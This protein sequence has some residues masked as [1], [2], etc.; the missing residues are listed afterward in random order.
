MVARPPS[1]ESWLCPTDADLHRALDVSARVRRARELGSAAIGVTMIASAPFLG[2]Y[3]LVFFALSV[4]NLQTLDWRLSRARHPARVIARS[5]LWTAAVIGGAAAATGGPVSPML[6]W[7]VIPC[8][9]AAARFR[10]EVVFVGTGITA[11]L[12]AAITF[13]VDPQGTIDHPVLLFVSI[14]LLVNL[15][16]IVSAVTSAEIEHRAEAILDPLT[17]LLNRNALGPR[18]VELETQAARSGESVALVLCDLDHFKAVNDTYGHE[19]GDRALCETAD[20]MRSVLRTFELIYRYGGEEFLI[21]LPGAT[22][23]HGAEVAERV[24]VAVVSARPGALDLT[25]SA[26][27]AAA[28]GHRV[29]L[30]SLFRAADAALYEA[31][32]A[33]R[34]RVVS[35]AA[36]P[37]LSPRATAA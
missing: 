12:A 28:A 5:F 14:A 18:F 31:K 35:E 8:A 23:A 27:V 6:P 16:A 22:P 36:T 29:D 2:W 37:L 30:G 34:N 10:R 9:L 33:G 19:H 20:A 4:I 7:I 13:G 3:I 1:T 11:L 15:V 24:R 25:V 26:G 32:R 17:G 21:V